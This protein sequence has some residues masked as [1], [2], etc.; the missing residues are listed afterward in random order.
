MEQH[1]GRMADAAKTLGVQR[2]NLYRKVRQLA[3]RRPV[4]A[5]GNTALLPS[6]VDPVLREQLRVGGFD[7]RPNEEDSREIL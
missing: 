4:P 5:L 7:Q 6:T 1:H 3:V 2:A